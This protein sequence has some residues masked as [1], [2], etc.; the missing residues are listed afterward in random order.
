MVAQAESQSPRRGGPSCDAATPAG[1]RAGGQGWR[2]LPWLLAMALFLVVLFR[3]AW[4][5]DDAFISFRTADNFV[6]GYG[7]TWNVHERV[8]T[9][10]HPLWLF[11]F[12]AVYAVTREPYYTGIFLAMAVSAAAVALF[13]C[14]IADFGVGAALGVL[15]LSLSVAFVDYSTSGLENPLT[16]LLLAAF[17]WRYFAWA[18]IS[19]AEPLPRRFDGGPWLLSFLAALAAVN[20]LDTILL[21]LPALLHVLWQ[22]RTWRC[23]WWMAV[24][25]LPLFLWLGFSLFYYGFPFPNTAYAKLN[26]GI[27]SAALAAQGG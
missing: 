12:T 7:L 27:G 1:M 19:D 23:L 4:L 18:A 3:S 20:R 13:A 26:N 21:L 16:H 2:H 17:L 9:Y 24:G 10:T 8:Q 6:H 14:K 15:A 25:A 22:R 5:C 11:L